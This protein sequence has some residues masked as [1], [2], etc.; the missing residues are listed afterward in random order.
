M[1]AMGSWRQKDAASGL[2][3]LRN[4]MWNASEL[5]STKITLDQLRLVILKIR[6]INISYR[7]RY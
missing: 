3:T 1:A 2:G 7:P 4:Q 6:H 5:R